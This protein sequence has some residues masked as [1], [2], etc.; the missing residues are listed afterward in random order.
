MYGDLGCD[1]TSCEYDTSGC[2]DDRFVDN[3]DGTVTDNM[4]CL[5]WEM[6]VAGSGCLHCVDDTYV[7][8]TAMG[9]W[10][11]EVNGHTNDSTG[12]TQ[13]GLG[14]YTDWRMPTLAEL[15]TI[16]DTSVAGCGAGSPCIDPVFGPTF[17]SFYWS[18][19][20][21][22][23]NFF[24][25]GAWGVSFGSGN[26]LNANKSVNLFARAVRPCS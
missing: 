16:L 19:T 15:L 5:M 12:S 11:S 20:T 21:N 18:S 2:T 10:I 7:W 1:S 4:E 25:F 22:A 24:P 14:G 26:V 13:S 8:D 3:S 9:D 23:F 6:K 17:A